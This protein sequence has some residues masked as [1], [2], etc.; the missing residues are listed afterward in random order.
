MHQVVQRAR[1]FGIFFKNGLQN[2]CGSRLFLRPTGI[3]NAARAQERED[4][5]GGGFVILRVIEG[6][7]LHRVRE[8]E[9]PAVAI[10]V[11][12]EYFDSIEVGALPWGRGFGRSGG[13][14]RPK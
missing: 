1:M 9:V 14:T 10:A 7:L 3:A 8:G 11:A 2:R 4:V 5:E 12:V 6:E 13:A